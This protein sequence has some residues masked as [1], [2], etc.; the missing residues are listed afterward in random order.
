MSAQD[1]L[2]LESARTYRHAC[3]H[4]T[5]LFTYVHINA[6]TYNT[7]TYIRNIVIETRPIDVKKMLSINQNFT[8]FVDFYHCIEGNIISYFYVIDVFLQHYR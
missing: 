1:A 5:Y 6:H 8:L 7:C 4:T 2:L 3:M